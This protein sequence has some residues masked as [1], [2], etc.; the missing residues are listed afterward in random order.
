MNRR[1]RTERKHAI[2]LGCSMAGLLASRVLS[3]HF[4]KVSLIERD[5]LPELAEQR[6][7]VPQGRHRDEKPCAGDALGKPLTGGQGHPPPPQRLGDD[8]RLVQAR[9]G[10]HSHPFIGISSSLLERS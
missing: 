3:D 6:R 2:V 7:G 4:E 5:A 9:I 10:V 8:L 1:L